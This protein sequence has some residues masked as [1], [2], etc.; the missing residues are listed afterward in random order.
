MPRTQLRLA[1]VIEGGVSLAVWM[2]GVAHEIDL[3]RRAG[4]RGREPL[5][6]E[7]SE[8]LRRWRTL[9]DDLNLDIVVDVIAGTSAGGLNG[10][11]LACSI[12][13][14]QPL[15]DL[16]KLWTETAQL[17][18][19]KLLRPPDTE[20]LDSLLDGRYFA[21]QLTAALRTALGTPAPNGQQ[22]P[23][24]RAWHPVSLLTTATALG[25]QARPWIDSAGR[26]FDVADHRRVYRFRHDPTRLRYV[27]RRAAEE[28]PP[29]PFELFEP[30]D[31]G[32]LQPDD[33]PTVARAA[34]A[35]AG[36]PAA[37]EPVDEA[38]HE[39][40]LM[41]QSLDLV[42][43]PAPLVDGGVLDNA[44]FE[45]LIG[46]IARREVDANWRRVI[47]YVVAN[48]GLATTMVGGGDE[49]EGARRVAREW[50]PVLTSTLRMS[51]ETSFRHGV[52]QLAQRSLD[53]ERLASG[54]EALLVQLLE[55]GGPNPDAVA[56]LY[57][58]YR[59]TRTASGILDAFL[60]RNRPPR[61]QRLTLPT[62]EE[63]EPDAATSWVPGQ[64]FERALQTGD[65]RWG[66]AV[67][68]RSTRLLLRQL[69]A[70]SES[71]RV[72]VDDTL[73]R[74]SQ[75]LTAVTAMRD[76]LERDIADHPG[77]SLLEAVNTAVETADAPRVL[78]AL[79]QKAVQAYADGRGKYDPAL[80]RQAVLTVEVLTQAVTG[81]RPFDRPAR[82][83]VIRMGPNVRTEVVPGVSNSG[84]N[85]E[86]GDWKLYGTQ[87][88][89]FGSFGRTEWRHHDFLW[90]RLDGAAHLI[91][92]LS[93]QTGSPLQ[94]QD[95]ARRHVRLAQEAVLEEERSS[96]TTREQQLKQ[97]RESLEEVAQLNTSRTL[98]AIRADDAGQKTAE[99]VVTDVLRML[100]INQPGT[101]KI[102]AQTGAWASVVL[103]RRLPQRLPAGPLQQI[104]RWATWIWPRPT[105]WR[106]IRSGD[107]R[108]RKRLGGRA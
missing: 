80:I 9:C 73:H 93:R 78:D 18:P 13:T 15:P 14:G 75:V 27:P 100:L 91:D 88:L 53:A 33:L 24:G 92:V 55:G 23:A 52:Q 84:R 57:P 19:G 59:T 47:G 26:R 41:P 44:P 65:F 104:S 25:V 22:T 74:L 95:T 68:D 28:L 31:P 98:N 16:K 70:W 48:D 46:E 2:S 66:T 29:D 96:G 50:F 99:A 64:D 58:L 39:A 30:A 6:P 97:M 63:A 7:C 69:H 17:E 90:G 4:S 102:L 8:A 10:A 5:P 83:D 105:L 60:V 108:G 56:S 101:P 51:S 45:P 77:D 103:A 72:D 89:H 107:G 67:A 82:F 87:L 35:T 86:F 49:A 54:P 85:S 42:T 11:L 36:F 3:L 106:R 61:P 21:D 76:H 38:D 94:D 43:A 37:F 81:R 62:L 34:R 20:P 32:E 12:A 1:L 40:D 79:V 71:A